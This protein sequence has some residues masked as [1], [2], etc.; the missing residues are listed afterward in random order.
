[1]RDKG[2]VFDEMRKQRHALGRPFP[3]SWIALAV[4]FAILILLV[5]LAAERRAVERA[6]GE[7]VRRGRVGAS[8]PAAQITQTR[9]RGR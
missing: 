9:G 2:L 3:E 6:S 7:K 8:T 1:M 4:G 5:S